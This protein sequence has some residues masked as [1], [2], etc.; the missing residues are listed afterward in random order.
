MAG[1]AEDRSRWLGAAVLSYGFRT[2]FL[3]GAIAA[4]ALMT[5]SVAVLLG[6]NWPGTVPARQR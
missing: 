6:W 1:D 5:V 4:I 3:L 2:F